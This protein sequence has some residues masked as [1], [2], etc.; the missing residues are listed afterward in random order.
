MQ[1]K[2]YL[3]IGLGLIGGSLA[4]AL[5]EKLG[6]RDISAIDKNSSDLEKALSDG[7]IDNAYLHDGVNYKWDADVIFICTPV[8]SCIEY[9]KLISARAGRNCIVT[10][11]CSTKSDIIQR[12]NSQSSSPC[13]IGGHPMTGSEHAGYASGYAHMFENAYYILTPSKTST[14]LAPKIVAILPIIPGLSTTSTII[15]YTGE[16]SAF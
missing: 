13:F 14:P 2:K 16:T 7:I 5:R 8:S 12:I 9:I 3:I 6:V 15:S 1:D 11:V 10:D 4:R